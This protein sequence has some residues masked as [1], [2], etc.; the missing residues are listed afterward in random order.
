MEATYSALN[1]KEIREILKRETCE[2]IDKIPGLK[3]G[4]TFH[5]AQLHFG[6]TM[7]AF[8]ADVPVPEKEF[9]F[10]I[11][12]EKTATGDNDSYLAKVEA[13]QLQVTKLQE[14]QETLEKLTSEAEEALASA[15]LEA[16]EDFHVDAGNDPNVI[17]SANKMSIP[18]LAT[19]SG[20]RIETT[21]EA[22]NFN[23]QL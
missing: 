8:P 9:I 20:K 4:L 5:R 3:V 15:K 22:S 12:S 18:V 17:R 1:G 10:V 11:N 21:V 19:I 23:K 7:E 2:R 6:F 14:Q 16:E 13:L